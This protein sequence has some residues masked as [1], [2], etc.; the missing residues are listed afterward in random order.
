[1]TYHFEY[2]QNERIRHFMLIDIGVMSSY[3]MSCRPAYENRVGF[4]FG[5]DKSI[6][7]GVEV[8]LQ[9]ALNS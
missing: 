9:L 2:S 6:I 3:G 4:R 7:S 5:S 1:M 8:Y